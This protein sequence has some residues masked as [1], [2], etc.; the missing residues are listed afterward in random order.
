MTLVEMLEE[1]KIDM[2]GFIVNLKA[3]RSQLSPTVDIKLRAVMTKNETLTAEQNKAK[4]KARDSY[5]A[6]LTGKPDQ[7][8]FTIIQSSRKVGEISPLRV[9]GYIAVCVLF[10][11]VARS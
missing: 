8:R 10:E 7:P 6:C 2:Q 5:I 9:E 3:D 1:Y 4:A 11:Y